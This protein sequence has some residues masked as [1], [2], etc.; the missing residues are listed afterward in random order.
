MA[1]KKRIV[2]E[3]IALLFILL[4]FV[5]FDRSKTVNAAERDLDD[6]LDDYYHAPPDY[7]LHLYV[8]ESGYGKV[9]MIPDFPENYRVVDSIGASQSG[10]IQVSFDTTLLTQNDYLSL[11]KSTQSVICDYKGD[12]DEIIGT[13]FKCDV[14][15]KTDFGNN[16][17]YQGLRAVIAKSELALKTEK[18]RLD[19]GETVGV[20]LVAN[21]FDYDEIL[22]SSS[23]DSVISISGTDSRKAADISV[24]ASGQGSATV[25]ARLKQDGDAVEISRDFFV[26]WEQESFVLNVSKAVLYKNESITLEVQDLPNGAG[27]TF[28]SSAS[29][30]V[31]VGKKTGKITALKKGSATVTAT[32]KIPAQGSKKASTLKLKCRITVKDGSST[33]IKTASA[34]EKALT[35]Q[36]GGRYKL[37]ADISGVKGINIKKGSYRL[38]LSGHTVKGSNQNDSL[39]K[40]S[41]GTLTITDSKGKGGISNL[42]DQDA[43]GCEKGTVN[44]YGG[45]YTGLCYAIYQEGSGTVN[46]YGGSFTGNRQA[47]ALKSGKLNIMSG[48]FSQTDTVYTGDTLTVMEVVG[49][50]GD[51]PARLTIEGGKFVSQAGYGLEILGEQN[52]VTINGGAFANYSVGCL[53]QMGGDTVINGGYFYCGAD[54]GEVFDVGNLS[55]RL[56][57]TMNGGS[58]L[59]EKVKIFYIQNTPDVTITG[60]RF[61]IKEQDRWFLTPYLSIV[62]TYRGKLTVPKGFFMTDEVYDQTPVGQGLIA[63]EF[64]RDENVKYKKNMTVTTPDEL[65]SMYLDATEKLIPKLEFKCSEDLY[66]ILAYYEGYWAEDITNSYLDY[67]TDS[68]F[69]PKNGKEIVNVTFTT[70]YSLPYQI[71]R[72]CIDPE[73]AKNASKEAIAYSKKID[74]IVKETVNDKMSD[75]EKAT[76]LHDYMVAKYSYDYSFAQKSYTIAGLLDDGKGVCQAYAMLYKT[77]CDRAGLECYLVSGLGGDAGNMDLHMWNVL[78]IDG[79]Y[80][81]VDVT[82]DDSAGTKKWLLKEEEE[83]Y[84]DGKHVLF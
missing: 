22:W 68:G 66:K 35:N 54:E 53:T 20:S 79:K 37:G 28:K 80:L 48:V 72:A 26:N 64:M 3:I 78:S 70:E 61:E 39:V 12:V 71:E 75:I 11:D 2:F 69:A 9:S 57:F 31:K 65:Y 56:T 33:V 82:F 77:L 8:S 18:S 62:N 81:F 47:I 19:A 40:T 52:K 16:V 55:N 15:V 44:I 50:D 21:G 7:E 63:T 24:T 1:G 76:A 29:K 49:H 60:G 67:D 13:E 51:N 74:K 23:N 36:K 73:A 5:S 42:Q 10:I 32:V 17:I 6:I 84:K 38:D 4:A 83:F 27:V 58:V 45:S 30:K 43:L 34:L 41:G 59:S 25:T 46:I 14:S